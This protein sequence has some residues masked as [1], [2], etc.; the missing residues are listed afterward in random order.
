M[1]TAARMN[2][3]GEGL[4]FR[5]ICENVSAPGSTTIHTEAYREIIPKYMDS[6]FGYKNA[7]EIFSYDSDVYIASFSMNRDNFGLWSNYADKEKGCIIG[8]DQSFFD[9]VDKNYYSILDD[10]I[11]ENAL[12]RILYVNEQE[13]LAGKETLG[14]KCFKGKDGDS[15]EKDNAQKD[16]D[17]IR[18]CIPSILEKLSEIEEKLGCR[19]SITR[20]A[21]EVIRT[22]IVDRLNEIRFLFKSVSYEYE[23]EMRML[24]CSQNPEV[25]TIGSGVIP[26]LYINVE[27]RLDNLTLILGSRVDLEQ[28][29]ELSVWTKSTGRVKQVIWSGLNRL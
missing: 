2:D 10:E 22:F 20:E 4:M 14:I 6:S 21:A 19:E 1:S 11:E 9:L 18:K 5:K 29:K 17:I 15:A 28:V 12:Y 7:D 27:K 13:L 23:E 16:I 26:R 8:F 24:R 3:A 25:D